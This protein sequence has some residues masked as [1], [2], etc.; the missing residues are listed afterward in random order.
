V[1]SPIAVLTLKSISAGYRGVQ[2]LSEISLDVVQNEIVAVIGPN[3]SGKSTLAKV[4][5]G[6]I[7][8]RGGRIFLGGRDVTGLPAWRRPAAGLAYVPQELNIFPNMTVA[9]NLR[10]ATEYTRPVSRADIEARHERAL[11]LFPN[12]AE[13]RRLRAGVLSGGER[14]L[15]AFAC[16]MIA[17]PKILVLDEP[18]AGLSPRLTAGIMETVTAIHRTGTAIFLIEQNVAAALAIAKRVVVLVNGA[19]RLTAAARDF[20]TKYNLRDLYFA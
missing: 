6:L 10:I 2:I 9:E 5:A 20:G 1:T 11:A 12:Y 7:P 15:L 3:G 18:S 4:L 19:T 13:K 8:P 17:S 14:Q 16:A